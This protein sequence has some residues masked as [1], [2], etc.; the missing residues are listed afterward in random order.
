MRTSADSSKL[1]AGCGDVASVRFAVSEV[2]A[3]FG[4]VTRIDIMTMAEAERR[5]AVC[6][7]QLES[8]AQE[9]GW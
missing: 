4:R 2:C 9:N 5:Q 7:L 3:E 8:E 1:L 6:F